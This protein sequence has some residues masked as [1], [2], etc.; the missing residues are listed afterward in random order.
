MSFRC[1]AS[2]PDT[3]EFGYELEAFG[4][5][6]SS[7]YA[8]VVYLG[9]KSRFSTQALLIASK[10]KE[11]DHPEVGAPGGANTGT[12]NCTYQDY[13]GTVSCYQPCPMLDRLE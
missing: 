9:I 12:I 8:A 2:E 4:D 11:A 7:A 13:T 3:K 1:V 5:A 6:L 10:R